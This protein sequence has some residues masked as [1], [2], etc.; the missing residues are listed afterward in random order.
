MRLVLDPEIER[1]TEA[2]I[3]AAFEVSHVLG[4]GFVEVVY[5]RALLREMERRKLA[6]AEEVPFKVSYKG[7]PVGTFYADIVVEKRVIVELKVAE[8]FTDAHL[9]QVVNYLRASGL[10]VGLLFNFGV[11]KVAVRRVLP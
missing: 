10:P 3:G 9:M 2:I 1:T 8:G 7:D 4:N 6:V 5:K 11:P